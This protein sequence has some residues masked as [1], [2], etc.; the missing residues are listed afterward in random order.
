MKK[1]LFCLLAVLCMG[2]CDKGFHRTDRGVIVDID[3]S[4]NYERVD[5]TSRVMVEVMGEKL[6]H[7]K[8]IQDLEFPKDSSLIVVPNLP[9]VPFKVESTD[10]SVFVMTNAL[11]AGVDRKFGGVRFQNAVTGEVILQEL[12]NGGRI[13]N[14]IESGGEW[15]TSVVQGFYGQDDEGLYGLGQHQA[16]EFNYKNKSE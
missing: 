9:K 14:P 6:I 8:A 7:V 11:I 1:I 15:K 5:Q 10:D 12:D 4:G 3:M 16:D 2:S 13:F